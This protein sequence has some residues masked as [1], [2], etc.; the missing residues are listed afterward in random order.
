M[1]CIIST[2]KINITKCSF[3]SLSSF[4]FRSFFKKKKL[5]KNYAFIMTY[6]QINHRFY[7][8]SLISLLKYNSFICVFFKILFSQ[9][10][11]SN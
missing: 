1:Y 2:N 6:L 5:T 10:N 8:K 11:T 9:P 4:S 3:R 7:N